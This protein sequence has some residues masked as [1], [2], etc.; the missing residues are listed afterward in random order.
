MSFRAFSLA[1]TLP[2]I[3]GN[4]S[5]SLSQNGVYCLHSFQLLHDAFVPCSGIP[6]MPS[7]EATRSCFLHSLPACQR[8]LL[9]SVL[10]R[11]IHF[12]FYCGLAVFEMNSKRAVKIIRTNM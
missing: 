7:V 8:S 6:L 12:V 4:L 9:D 10:M 5:Q 1:M 3:S 2:S 11:C